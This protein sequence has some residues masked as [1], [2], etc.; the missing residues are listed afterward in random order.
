MTVTRS[1]F[2]H[3]TAV[4]IA[5]RRLRDSGFTILDHNWTSGE[6]AI[7]LLAV[8]R[9]VFV[10]CIVKSRVRSRHYATPLE[11]VTR[12]Y[13]DRLRRAALAWL[14]AHGTRYSQVRIDVIGL[15]QEGTGGYTI[16]HIRAVG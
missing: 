13:S 15:V 2:G 11:A 9:D 12:P 6:H 14:N 7:D 3:N 4:A 1:G 8:E 5:E 10:I 16:E